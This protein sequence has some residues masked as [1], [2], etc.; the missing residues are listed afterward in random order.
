MKIIR[1]FCQAKQLLL[2]D[3]LKLTK[4]LKLVHQTPVSYEG[5]RKALGYDV[6]LNNIKFEEN[7]SDIFPLTL[8]L[9]K[10]DISLF[11][12]KEF[13]TYLSAINNYICFSKSPYPQNEQE[14][15]DALRIIL[16]HG[17]FIQKFLTLQHI[18]IYFDSRITLY[19]QL[20]TQLK[21]SV[22]DHQPKNTEEQILKLF[23][24]Q[25]DIYDQEKIESLIEKQIEPQNPT[26]KIDER[27]KKEF[28]DLIDVLQVECEQYHLTTQLVIFEII[29]RLYFDQDVEI[30]EKKQQQIYYVEKQCQCQIEQNLSSLNNFHLVLYTHMLNLNQHEVNILSWDKIINELTIRDFATMTIDDAFKIWLLLYEIGRQNSTVNDKIIE[31]LM[32]QI[33]LI[34]NK[35]YVLLCELLIETKN[36]KTVE[37]LKKWYP[38]I[39]L[40][41]ETPQNLCVILDAFN[42]AKLLNKLVLGKFLN[43][44]EDKM[45]QLDEIYIENILISLVDHQYQHEKTLQRAV[46]FELFENTSKHFL[47]GLLH[48]CQ[49]YNQSHPRVMEI[50]EVLAQVLTK[51][52]DESILIE[53]LRI[54][55]TAIRRKNS[56]H[57]EIIPELKPFIKKFLESKEGNLMG[58][59]S[60]FR[61]VL[62][63]LYN[64][65]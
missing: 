59:E 23:W 22:R 29:S 26:M 9:I 17:T 32:N 18:V 64:I 12:F 13:T 1:T 49:L 48:Y 6:I 20:A 36:S 16:D 11:D 39:D 51:E 40:E 31:K 21:D 30:S 42:S 3:K 52:Y 50:Q 4:Y 45:D 2:S 15:Q 19:C 62:Q 43:A 7:Q 35:Y 28:I 65:K 61:S 5:V 25:I 38:K 10:R 37:F 63:R 46:Q 44:L 60:Q 47:L 34:S 55:I 54:L 33:E 57:I 14:F 27:I 8:K 56:Q 41:N 58:Q 53:L 24:E